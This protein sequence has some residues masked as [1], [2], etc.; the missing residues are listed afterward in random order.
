[1]FWLC[2]LCFRLF[3]LPSF[4]F[5][6]MQTFSCLMFIQRTIKEEKDMGETIISV[7]N[8]VQVHPHLSDGHT[9]K[10]KH[11]HTHIYTYKHFVSPPQEQLLC[12]QLSQIVATL[13]QHWTF[14]IALLHDAF[15]GPCSHW[16]CGNIMAGQWGSHIWWQWGWIRWGSFRSWHGI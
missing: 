4:L 15:T 10:H 14:L 16:L 11:A 9:G 5:L 8:R 2:S 1:M 3:H 6:S 12:W 13:C 7:N